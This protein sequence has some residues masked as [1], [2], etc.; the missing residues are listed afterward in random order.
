[1][2][3]KAALSIVVLFVFTAGFFQR[4][5]AQSPQYPKEI[6]GYKV[7]LAVVELAVVERQEPSS[8]KPER[9]V[10]TTKDPAFLDFGTPELAEVTPLGVRFK[11][12]LLISPV[13]Q[14]GRAEFLVFENMVIN[15][16]K[17]EIDDYLHEFELPNKELLTLLD[18]LEIYTYLPSAVLAAIDDWRNSKEEW[19]LTGRV[20]VFGKFKKGIFSA[21]RCVPIELNLMISNPLRTK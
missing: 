21:K 16:T 2:F 6:R 17:V 5:M 11:I 4:V 20:Y 18:P 14:K 15:G 19:E 10:G 13:K 7:E 1:M 3:P 9:N 12:P 8:R